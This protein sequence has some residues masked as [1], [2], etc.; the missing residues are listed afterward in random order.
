MRRLSVEP[1]RVP[2]RDFPR[3]KSRLRV[4]PGKCQFTCA[5]TYARR[6]VM[7]A[8]TGDIHRLHRRRHVGRCNAVIVFRAGPAVRLRTGGDT[9]R[10]RKIDSV[11][12][13]GAGSDKAIYKATGIA[14]I[15]AGS[16]DR[17]AR[18]NASLARRVVSCNYALSVR[19]LF[20]FFPRDNRPWFIIVLLARN[21]V[22]AASRLAP[23]ENA[24]CEAPSRDSADAE[25]SILHRSAEIYA[26]SSY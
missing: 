25:Y 11:I 14:S 7:L 13:G 9:R 24:E 6:G 23:E 4:R 10:S 16:S 17:P 5:R 8:I 26:S 20:F 12:S 22:P 3:I 19:F 21:N 15:A 2:L 1:D 18:E